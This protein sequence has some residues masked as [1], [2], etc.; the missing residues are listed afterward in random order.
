MNIET[1]NSWRNAVRLTMPIFMGY[2]AAGVAYGMLATNAGLPAWFTIIMCFTVFSGTAQYA[3]IPFFVAGAGVLSV[4]LS[5]LLMSLRFMFYTLNMHSIL[6]TSRLKR[7]FTLTY[8]TDENFALLATLPVEK[9]QALI[10]KTSILGMLY[11]TFAAIVGVLLGDRVANYIPHLDFALPCLFAILA[12]E[13]YRNQKQWLPL[14][15]ALIGFLLAR[16]ISESN[17][18]LVA[19]LIAIG[20]VSFLP[21]VKEKGGKNDI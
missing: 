6:P 10:F 7:F 8:L 5:T 15:V 11:W 12:F 4:F 1:E 2:F 19:I 3:A 18:L 16:Q 17:V 21:T 9:R 14:L 20:L 13:Q